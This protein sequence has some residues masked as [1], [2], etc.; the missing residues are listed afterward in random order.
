MVAVSGK[1]IEPV[2]GAEAAVCVAVGDEVVGVGAVDGGS[3][4]L[5]II[6]AIGRYRP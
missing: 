4:G 1:R 2:G 3:L 6:S 5:D